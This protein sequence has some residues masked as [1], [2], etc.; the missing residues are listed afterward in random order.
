MAF[1]LTFL[2]KGGTGRTTLAIAA[3]KALAEQGQRVLLVGG[4]ADPAL[5]LLLGEP[6][7][8]VTPREVS[9]NLVAAQIQTTELL[10]QSWSEVKALEE[11]YVRT[12]FFKAVYGQELGVLP[13]MDEALTLYA[14]KEWDACGQHDVILYD[15]S[16]SQ[17]LLRMLGMPEIASWYGR[18]FRQVF[19]ESDLGRAISPFVQPV[20]AAVL[21]NP[22]WGSNPFDQQVGQAE[23][24]FEQG[25]AAI[26]DPQRVLA[27]LVTT[28]DPVAQA[29]AQHLWGSAQQINLT[30]GGVLLNRGIVSEPL[31]KAFAPLHI[32]AIPTR[33][34][35]DWHPLMAALPPWQQPTPAPQPLSIDLAQRQV[36]LFLPG[37][38]KKQVKLT[39]SGPELTIEAGDQRHNLLLPPELKGQAVTGA[40]FDQGYLTIQL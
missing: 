24:L 13:G 6:G 28:E 36:K 25:K 16:S 11:Q 26:A 7:L 23:N 21:N 2:G 12:P 1:I 40:K 34:S 38:D 33:I 35:D 20:A 32:H 15:S 3:A 18:R 29:S 4:S 8:S 30:V 14:L 5:G 22:D 17:S 37:L 19:A 31:S 39:Q 9:A 10:A 27:Y